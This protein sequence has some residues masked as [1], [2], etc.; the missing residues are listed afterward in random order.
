MSE[1]TILPSE[2]KMLIRTRLVFSFKPFSGY[3]NNMKCRKCGGKIKLLI[4]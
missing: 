2:W 1:N 3:T 4:A